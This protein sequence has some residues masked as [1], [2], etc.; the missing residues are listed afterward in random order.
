MSSRR[1]FSVV[2]LVV[3]IVVMGILSTIAFAAFRSTQAQARD[4]ALKSDAESIARGLESYYKT[5]NPTYNV[6]AG[7]YP[8]V[9]EILHAGGWDQPEVGP[10]VYGGYMS[11]WLDGVTPSAVWPE[12]KFGALVILV[13][14][15]NGDPVNKISDT[16]IRS[17]VQTKKVYYL[18]IMYEN[19]D[20]YG[21]DRQ[22]LC[23]NKV[24]MC[25]SFK[26]Y[27]RT[28]VGDQIKVIESKHQ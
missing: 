17:L 3:V 2:E 9:A 15:L 20:V 16:T 14:Q 11:S 7:K 18:P 5:G 19:K 21:D 24:S 28:E 26:L 4:D 8:G 1:G 23:I 12:H 25:T 27:Y 22:T 13:S 10:I 6:P